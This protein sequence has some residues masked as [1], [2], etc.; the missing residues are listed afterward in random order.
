MSLLVEERREYVNHSA[1]GIAF[2][3]TSVVLE[4]EGIHANVHSQRLATGT[5]KPQV[6]PQ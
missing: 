5:S 2:E 4:H 1:S 6:F 3:T